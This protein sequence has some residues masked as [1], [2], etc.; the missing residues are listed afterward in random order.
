[1]KKQRTSVRG[2][3][4]FD[5]SCGEAAAITFRAKSHQPFLCCDIM[6]RALLHQP[7]G[8]VKLEISECGW[9]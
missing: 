9:V 2:C 7:L 3:C 1:M 6:K 4:F 8:L 5:A